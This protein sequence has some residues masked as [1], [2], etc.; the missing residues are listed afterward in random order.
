M[1]SK[2]AWGTKT[3]CTRAE[4]NDQP[5]G[6]SPSKCGEKVWKSFPKCLETFRF[7]LGIIPGMILLRSFSRSIARSYPLPF[8]LSCFIENMLGGFLRT[9]TE[10]GDLDVT[11]FIFQPQMLNIWPIDLHLP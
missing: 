3:R 8:G 1:G 9:S 4:Y 6:W 5:G 10:E 11:S 7:G 2:D